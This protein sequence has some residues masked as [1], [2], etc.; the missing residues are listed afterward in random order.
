[1]GTDLS[2]ADP[3]LDI[4]NT[5]LSAVVFVHDYVQLQF[6]GPTINVMTPITV[7]SNGVTARSGETNFRNLLCDQLSKT[8]TRAHASRGDTLMLTFVDGATLAISLK[9][10]DY[11]GPE[12]VV[13]QGAAP[14]W[15]VL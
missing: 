4:V 8:V 3:L 15:P 2:D 9:D 12:A 6:D 13:I 5:E 10:H 14:R 7:S 11:I 1:M